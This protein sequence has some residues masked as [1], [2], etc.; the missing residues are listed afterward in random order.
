MLK[1]SS[2]LKKPF[3]V[4]GI[5]LSVILMFSL[6]YWL[7][8]IPFNSGS[9]ITQLHFFDSLYFSVVTITTLGYGDFSP[10]GGLGKLLTGSE[11]ILGILI[12]G[13]FLNSLSHSLAKKY[14]EELKEKEEL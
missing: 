13:L 6:F 4:L 11:A 8:N 7:F 5:Y 3:S 2:F 14:Q 12:L 9:G 1:G 10:V